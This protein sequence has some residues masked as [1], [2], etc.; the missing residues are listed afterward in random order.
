MSPTQ[1]TIAELKKR[2][3]TCHI[4]E[5]WNHFAKIRQDFGGFADILAYR[6]DL[7]GVFAIQTTSD[8]NVSARV[9]KSLQI[10]NL[11]TWLCAGNTFQVWGWGRKGERGKR[12]TWTLRVIPV[13]WNGQKLFT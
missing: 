10:S 5:K 13:L 9:T 6:N 11:G 8:S 2:G 3:Y 12:K 1:R 7:A 4:V